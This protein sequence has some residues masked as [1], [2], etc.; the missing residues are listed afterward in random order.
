MKEKIKSP[1]KRLSGGLIAEDTAGSRRCI[2]W[3][4]FPGKKSYQNM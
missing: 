4:I 3:T 1:E 2:L